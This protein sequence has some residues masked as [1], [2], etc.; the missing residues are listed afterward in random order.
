MRQY[1]QLKTC[2][3][4]PTGDRSIANLASSGLSLTGGWLNKDCKVDH[5][6]VWSVGGVT[7]SL[8]VAVET[9]GG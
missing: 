3:C 9:T 6:P 8:S 2:C 7:I 1:D 5:G 4:N